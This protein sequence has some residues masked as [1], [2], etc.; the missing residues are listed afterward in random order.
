VEEIIEAQLDDNLRSK[1]LLNL[2]SE[3]TKQ[4]VEQF[5]VTKNL[6]LGYQAA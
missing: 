6:D 5:E 3:W 4:Q 2:F 1:I